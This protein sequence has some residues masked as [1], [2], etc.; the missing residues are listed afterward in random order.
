MQH[1]WKLLIHK[2]SGQRIAWRPFI[3][4]MVAHQ[5]WTE[6]TGTF[7]LY[8]QNIGSQTGSTTW[9]CKECHGWDYKGKDG[10]YGNGSN[11]FTGITGVFQVQRKPIGEIYSVIR[12][13]NLPL[14]EEDIWDLTRFLKE[15]L[16][17][18]DKYIIFSGALSKTASGTGNLGGPIYS[19]RC[20]E[21]HGPDGKEI[22]SVVVGAVAKDNPWETLH[23]IA[24][25][26]PGTSMPSMIDRGLST[27]QLIDLLTYTQTLS[28]E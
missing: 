10:A 3:W 25:G 8:P 5:W 18:M 22:S 11:H 26:N 28:Q 4:F 24:F 27:Q 1:H 14:S 9:R 21:C 16:I 19:G 7:A 12:N 13:K 6:P 2:I 20:S 23:K 17:E 15:G